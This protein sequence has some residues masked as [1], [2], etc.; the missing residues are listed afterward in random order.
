M[1]RAELAAR[2]TRTA[3]IALQALERITALLDEDCD[4]TRVALYNP[5]A[6]VANIRRV[7]EQAESDL[8]TL[9]RDPSTGDAKAVTL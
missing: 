5:R 9:E 4:E 3:E 1:S 6:T 7:L 8:T 2:A